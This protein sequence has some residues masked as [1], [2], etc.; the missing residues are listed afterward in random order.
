[1][2]KA[3]KQWGKYHSEAF[4]KKPPFGIATTRSHNEVT[5]CNRAYLQI[6]F[7]TEPKVKHK[8]IEQISAVLG[9]V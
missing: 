6:K 5:S 1:M 8:N 3:Q 7:T 9:E 4:T 2:G